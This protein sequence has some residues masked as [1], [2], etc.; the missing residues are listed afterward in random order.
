[1]EEYANWV[2]AAAPD[3]RAKLGFGAGAARMYGEH[4]SKRSAQE[5]VA[6]YQA[7]RPQ[8]C[9]AVLGWVPVG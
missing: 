6:K 9:S 7:V 4:F 1:M 2:G 3:V 8:Y 5:V